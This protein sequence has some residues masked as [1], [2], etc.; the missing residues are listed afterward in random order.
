MINE[1]QVI[2]IVDDKEANLI[3]LERLLESS[4]AKVVRAS[5]G[6]DALMASLHTQ[7]ALAIVDVQMPEMDLPKMQ[8]NFRTVQ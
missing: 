5:S 4:D 6:N 8:K 1:Q 2:L 3:A 7:F